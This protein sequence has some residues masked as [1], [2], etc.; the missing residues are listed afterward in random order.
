MIVGIQIRFIEGSTYWPGRQKCNDGILDDFK[1]IAG[2]KNE[3]DKIFGRI[4][5]NLA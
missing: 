1:T 4:I 3:L 5:F 2:L